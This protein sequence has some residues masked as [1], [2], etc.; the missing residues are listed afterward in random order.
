MFALETTGVAMAQY[1]DARLKTVTSGTVRRE[2]ALLRHCFEVA[3]REWGYPISSNPV[4]AIRLPSPGK[5]R[6]RR[7]TA[8]ERARLSE[9]TAKSKTWYLDA[10]VELAMQTAMRRGEL[11]K[12]S[13][14]NIDFQ[15]RLATLPM[16]K[17]GDERHVP[18]TTSAASILRALPRTNEVVFPVS[19]VALRQSW[20]RTIAK[21]DL[22]DFRFH[23]LRHEAISR[24]FESGLTIPEVAV[25]SGHRD[26]RMLMAYTHL[27]PE[28]IAKKLG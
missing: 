10:I 28:D 27:R 23:D 16:T 3:R 12:L 4:K 15:R 2:L 5:A 11:L 13:W 20:E 19:E 18:L 21:A 26:V 9:A 8:A 17:N 6:N 25:I 22:K 7:L 24:F 1:R 14:K